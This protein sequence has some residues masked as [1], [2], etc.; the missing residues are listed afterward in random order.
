MANSSTLASAMTASSR[1][2]R[3]RAAGDG[4]PPSHT[5]RVRPRCTAS[6]RVR[7]ALGK[8]AQG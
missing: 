3:L 7:R 6:T 8:R 5:R 4:P 2:A 1:V